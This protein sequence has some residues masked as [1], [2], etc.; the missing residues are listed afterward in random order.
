MQ[1][2]DEVGV[3]WELGEPHPHDGNIEALTTGEASIDHKTALYLI[4]SR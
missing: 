2:T 4:V 3:V 1:G